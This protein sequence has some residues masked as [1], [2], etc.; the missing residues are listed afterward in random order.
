MLVLG[1]KENQSVRIGDRI[2]ITIREVK[3]NK[4]KLAIDAP[5]WIQVDREEIWIAKTPESLRLMVESEG[6]RQ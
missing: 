1:R 3:G 2:K 6:A 4:V 5:K